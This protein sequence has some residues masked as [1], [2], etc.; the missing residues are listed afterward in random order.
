[1]KLAIPE[2]KGNVRFHFSDFS[3][4][5][6]GTEFDKPL[7]LGIVTGKLSDFKRKLDRLDLS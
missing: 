5:G 7:R 1:M 3:V 4:R 2:A 6:T